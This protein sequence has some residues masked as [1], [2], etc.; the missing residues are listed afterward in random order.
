MVA[1]VIQ[2]APTSQAPTTQDPTTTETPSLASSEATKEPSTAPVVENVPWSGP[3]P[4]A[5]KEPSLPKTRG[6]VTSKRK[7][8]QKQRAARKN[9]SAA[10]KR[11]VT[12]KQ[13]AKARRRSHWRKYRLH[14]D[15]SECP[16]KKEANEILP[17]EREEEHENWYES[18]LNQALSDLAEEKQTVAT[19]REERKKLIRELN[20]AAFDLAK[21]K[22][23]NA[24]L[25]NEREQDHTLGVGVSP[26][27]QVVE[28][29]RI[30]QKERDQKREEQNRELMNERSV[31]EVD[32]GLRE[33]VLAAAKERAEEEEKKRVE[34]ELRL[35]KA[36]EQLKEMAK[37][38]SK[39]R[40]ELQEEIRQRQKELDMAKEKAEEETER[41]LAAEKRLKETEWDLASAKDIRKVMNDIQE[42]VT[43][44][45]F[46]D[47]IDG[48][49]K[50]VDLKLKDQ[51][52]EIMKL[53]SRVAKKLPI[54]TRLEEDS[55]SG[56]KNMVCQKTTLVFS[57]RVQGSE[58]R[59]NEWKCS[60]SDLRL[61][62]KAAKCVTNIAANVS[63]GQYVKAAF[64]AKNFLEDC[65][66]SDSDAY[67]NAMKNPHLLSTES[68]KLISLL[69]LEGFYN[70]H[71]YNELTCE[72]EHIPNLQPQTRDGGCC[73]V[74]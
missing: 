47:E 62:V 45:G 32:H 41:R 43:H 73:I 63:S 64:D 19:L 9:R 22:E 57:Q 72:W 6:R 27:T 15:F 42:Q 30:L 65:Q 55:G 20:L 50:N 33:N 26:L 21:E 66:S 23:A 54:P 11:K 52:E 48:L 2:K 13:R 7:R 18:E 46:G 56:L 68:D 60:S 67:K 40:E 12:Q 25:Q 5:V 10:R 34:A 69:L 39:E 61:W 36:K 58:T 24:T 4:P 29:V 3:L 51:K 37:G 49:M 70:E 8:I 16:D 1:E 44:L 35:N 74:C 38:E 59:T 14:N 31:L 53:V 71:E 17:K 28:A